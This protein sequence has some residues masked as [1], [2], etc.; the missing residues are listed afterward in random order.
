MGD[1]DETMVAAV[2]EG[3]SRSPVAMN[4]EE[5]WRVGPIGGLE[6]IYTGVEQVLGAEDEWPAVRMLTDA[7]I[8]PLELNTLVND[9]PWDR[10]TDALTE[11]RR[12]LFGDASRWIAADGYPDGL[13]LAITDSIF[14]TGSRYQSVINV[15]NRCRE[16]R[17]VQGGDADQDPG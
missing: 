9:P 17:Q 3:M 14:S 7:P 13:A 11:A 2:P 12:S 4:M 10:E 15:V 6:G 8:K 1:S 5:I 16:Y